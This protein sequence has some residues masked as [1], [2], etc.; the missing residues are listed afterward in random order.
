MRPSELQALPRADALGQVFDVEGVV[1]A[2]AEQVF[3]S[4]TQRLW[5]LVIQDDEGGQ[6]VVVRHGFRADPGAGAPVDDYRGMGVREPIYVGQYVLARGY[7][8]QRRA[9]TIGESALPQP[10][11]VLWGTNFRRRLEPEDRVEPVASL[12]EIQ[13]DLIRDR[14]FAETKQWDEPQLYQTLQWARAQGPERIRERIKSGELEIGEWDQEV[15]GKWQP[16]VDVRDGADRPFTDGAR[17]KWFKTSGLIASHAFEGWNSVPAN[18]WAVDSFTVL[19]LNTDHYAHA[20]IRNISAFPLDAYEDIEGVFKEHVWIYG[21]FYKNHT[22]ETKRGREGM[23]GASPLTMPMFIVMHVEPVVYDIDAGRYR[24]FM[25]IIAGSIV[26]LGLIFWLVFVRGESKEAAR[27]E[28]Y[29]IKLRQ[30]MRAKGQGPT[31]PGKPS[32]G[33]PPTGEA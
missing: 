28:A 5:S 26:L 15:F 6:V 3:E 25:W 32:E 8:M 10:A 14:F 17:G 20:N 27:L 11:P 16:E 30:R 4:D 12:D 9:G 13:W 21:V 7:Y 22:F 23:Q 33:E 2:R 19:D 31:L 1:V 18:K 24:A 29:R